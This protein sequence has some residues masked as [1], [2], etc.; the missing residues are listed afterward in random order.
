MRY[1]LVV[2]LVLVVFEAC[3]FFVLLAVAVLVDAPVPAFDDATAEDFFDVFEAFGVFDVFGAAVLVGAG[4]G[5]TLV[6]VTSVTCVDVT[7]MV[8]VTLSGC[9]APCA[10]PLTEV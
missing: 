8:L 1:R 5:A 7:T 10:R 3:E 2:G 4:A 6:V 9:F